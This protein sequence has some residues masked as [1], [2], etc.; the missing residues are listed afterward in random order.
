MKNIIWAQYNGSNNDWNKLVQSNSGSP[1]QLIE[2]SEYK[3]TLGWES[4]RLIA[5]NNEQ[6]IFAANILVKKYVIFA[7]CYIP[8]GGFGMLQVLDKKF[9]HVI[10]K[11]IGVPYIY[12]R[13]SFQQAHTVSLQGSLLKN[14]WR[15]AKL[16]LGSSETMMYDLS[17]DENSR[18]LMASKNWRHNYKRSLKRDINIYTPS[19]DDSIIIKN[20]LENMQRYK[21]LDTIFSEHEIKN[22][23]IKL[24]GILVLYYALNSNGDLLGMRGALISGDR[25]VDFIAASTE[26][27]RKE[28]SS[29]ALFWELS[30]ECKRRGVIMYDMGGI[31]KLANHGVY[32]FKKGTGSVIVK[33]L[34]GYEWAGCIVSKIVIN[35]V[36]LLIASK[37]TIK[38]LSTIFRRHSLKN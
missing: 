37:N 34:G 16:K 19:S 26:C 33:Y 24:D 11:I 36:V 12:L 7:V 20:I 17:H 9:H 18:L 8:G 13:V 35:V 22:I 21:N 30:K 25:A 10:C 2:W 14:K 15:K 3:K 28:Y 29:Y 23:L 31:D 4:I 6:F 1:Y 38:Q 32:N 27:G 5:S